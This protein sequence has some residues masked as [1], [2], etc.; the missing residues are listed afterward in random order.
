MVPQLIKKRPVC[1]LHDKMENVVV[2]MEKEGGGGQNG[3]CGGSKWKSGGSAGSKC[4]I[5]GVQGNPALQR[6]IHGKDYFFHLHLCFD[7]P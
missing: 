6:N 5:L 2:K 3:K 4:K 1:Q 7:S